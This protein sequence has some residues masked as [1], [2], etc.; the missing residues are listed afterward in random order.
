MHLLPFV[1][2][3]ATHLPAGTW[4]AGFHLPLPAIEA[5][6]QTTD[7]ITLH[8]LA[9]VP[10]GGGGTLGHSVGS[11]RVAGSIY[12]GGV[13]T[14][15]WGYGGHGAVT[16]R[17]E[18]AQLGVSSGAL[19]TS[20]LELTPHATANAA[21]AL[22]ARWT[23]LA[24]GALVWDE[25]VLP[26]CDG[27]C[28]PSGGLALAGA[29]RSWERVSVEG[30]AGVARAEPEGIDAIPMGWLGATWSGRLWVH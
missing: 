14:I 17:G 18:K 2:P 6:L 28:G 9:G 8:A 30:A 4:S 7:A 26:R 24:E 22:N 1:L 12:W 16:W 15:G 21:Q 10:A 27:V 13:P 5:Q 29:R 19:Y 3:T 23:L 11:V 25:L 20:E